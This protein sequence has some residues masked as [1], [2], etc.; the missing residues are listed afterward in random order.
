MS[1]SHIA[2]ALKQPVR[3]EYSGLNHFAL[4][5]RVRSILDR[6]QLRS[7]LQVNCL[8]DDLQRQNDGLQREIEGLRVRLRQFAQMQ[9]L[10]GMLQ[11]SHK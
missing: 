9:E 4:Y 2:I 6:L 5:M 11:E 3:E 8:A 1:D 7:N 10:A